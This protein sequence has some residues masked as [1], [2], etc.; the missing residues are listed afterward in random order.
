MPFCVMRIYNQEKRRLVGR[1]LKND[2]ARQQPAPMDPSHGPPSR[3][4]ASLQARRKYEGLNSERNEKLT[5][6][7]LS[8]ASHSP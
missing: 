7:S 5:V 6:L 8:L 3:S 1:S 2:L 4:G